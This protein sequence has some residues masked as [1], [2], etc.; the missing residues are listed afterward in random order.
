MICRLAASLLSVNPLCSHISP[1]PEITAS[2][3]LAFNRKAPEPA[4]SPITSPLDRI[5]ALLATR[6]VP[7]A[8][9]APAGAVRD[10]VFTA[11]IRL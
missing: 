10:R 11:T 1:E 8:Y 7:L 5:V 4:T 3:M 9:I 6:G 2:S